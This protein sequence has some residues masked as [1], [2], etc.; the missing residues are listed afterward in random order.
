MNDLPSLLSGYRILD[1][2]DE[3]GLLCGSILGSLGVDVVKIERPGGDPARNIG[4]F[5]K[6]TPHPE[7]SLYWLFCNTNKRG[8]TLDITKH[9][10]QD[11]LKKLVAKADFII[12]SFEPGYMQSLGLGYS[13]LELINPRI[14]MTSITPF[15]QTGPYAHYKGAD[16][17]IWALGGLMYLLGFPDRPPVQI[18]VPQ[19][20][21]QGGLHASV[22][23]MVAHYHRQL[24]GEGQWVDVS[25]QE[26]IIMGLN[27][28]ESEWDLIGVN[29]RR[30]GSLRT[31]FRPD[32]TSISWPRV[33]QC[34]D[35]HIWFNLGTAGGVTNWIL[36]STNAL[37]NDMK[38]DGRK[39]VIILS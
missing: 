35:G 34:K 14:I 30:N 26:S 32:K 6:D 1:L 15:G 24:T 4:P 8:L 20:F 9:D 17:I 21:F 23:S 3:K 22:G 31:S 25:I 19:S 5:Y 29:R 18:S 7:K 37:I 28:A 10:G 36:A 11:I 2:T 39:K 38:A 33:W 27:G 12:E 13:Q 16:M